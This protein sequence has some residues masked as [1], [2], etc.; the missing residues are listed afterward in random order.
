LTWFYD[1][2]GEHEQTQM[3]LNWQDM[4]EEKAHQQLAISK[5]QIDYYLIHKEYAYIKKRSLST[6]L[7]NEKKNLDKHFYTRT[8][9]M[10]RSIEQME[11]NN[12]RNTIKKATEEALNSVLAKIQNPQERK[13][14]HIGSFNS[15]LQGLR[16]GRMTYEDDVLLPMLQAEIKAKLDPL[17][18]LSKEEESKLFALTPQQK[19]SLI[20][21]DARA[22]IQ[23]LANPPDVASAAV[24]NTDI[25]K[26]IVSRMKGR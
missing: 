1:A 16:T 19:R 9:D 10:L 17:T 26:N 7:E 21:N 22:K 6:F 5:D 18:K 25:Y 14:F 13:N 3:M 2:F 24:K 4:V 8:V 23:Y 11:N 12:V 15:A 20:D